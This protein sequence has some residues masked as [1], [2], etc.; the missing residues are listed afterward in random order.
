MPKSALSTADI[1]LLKD[2]GMPIKEIARWTGTTDVGVRARLSP[3]RSRQ[4]NKNLHRGLTEKEREAFNE[5]ERQRHKRAQKI[6]LET[7]DHGGPWSAEE[8]SFLREYGG[9]RTALELALHLRR[10]YF[11]VRRAAERYGIPL[12][13]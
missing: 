10:T 6:S 5:Q 9:I 11:S 1:Q 8:V 4:Y 7:A 3:E 12:R 2:R 13:K